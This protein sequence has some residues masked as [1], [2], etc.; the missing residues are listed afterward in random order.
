MIPKRRVLRRELLAVAAAAAVGARAPLAYGQAAWQPK[1]PI[2]VLVSFPTGGHLDFIM[3]AIAPQMTEALGQPFLV[4]NRPG[5][6]GN[7]AGSMAARAAPDGLTLLAASADTVAV[8]PHLYRADFDPVKDLEPITQL[9]SLPLMIVA[10]AGF[11]ASDA[12]SLIAHL[13]ASPRTLSYG[14]P[15]IGSSLHLVA[16]V[17]QRETGVKLNHVPYKG[18]AAA[19]TDLQGG[20]VDLVF[21]A[22]V[23]LPQVREGKFKLLAVVGRRRLEE[24][25]N[26]G[27]LTE[28]G[29]KGFERDASFVLMAPAGTPT[30]V[31]DR[32]NGEVIRAMNSP[33]VQEQLRARNLRSIVNSP[34]DARRALQ[35][36][37]EQ[38]GRV[39]REAGIKIE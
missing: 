18:L 6:N 9:I 14:T 10:P 26:V 27:T 25:P 29:L 39:I 15:G 7:V 35:A 24:F 17:F 3:R 20:H 22:G 32:I 4:E 23:S 28:A 30:P 31:I 12:S 13:K 1:Q 38:Q 16:E 11:P 21:D 34:A 2:R 8:N 37:I 19:I 33:G 36:E 5:A